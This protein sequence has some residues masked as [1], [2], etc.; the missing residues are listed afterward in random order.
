MR[1]MKVNKPSAPI[2]TKLIY[3]SRNASA[4]SKT[5]YFYY[6]DKGVNQRKEELIRKNITVNNDDLVKEIITSYNIKHM[7][8]ATVEEYYQFKNQ[9]TMTSDD[10]KTIDNMI[11]QEINSSDN[12]KIDY[13]EAT[14]IAIDK[15]ASTT[16]KDNLMAVTTYNNYISKRFGSTGLFSGIYESIDDL[17]Q[18]LSEH[19]NT[20][21]LPIISLKEKDAYMYNLDTEDDWKEKAREY[22][23]E[24]AKIV[25]IEKEN[26]R[27]LCA[28]HEKTDDKINI[29]KD[30]GKQPHLHF[31]IWSPKQNKRGIE[32]L[33]KQQL[34]KMRQKTSSIFL[35]DHLSEI[36]EKENELRSRLRNELDIYK[37]P[38]YQQELWEIQRMI[39]LG[40][41]GKGRL[42]H[43]SINNHINV[44]TIIMN[45]IIMKN[46]L[47]PQKIK[48]LE[49]LGLPQ[50]RYVIQERILLFSE[51]QDKMEKVIDTLLNQ[52][53][54]KREFN[55]WIEL[56]REITST[57]GNQKEVEFY[58]NNAIREFRKVIFN[59]LLKNDGKWY[60]SI[61]LDKKNAGKIID[62]AL[63][64]H[65]KHSTTKED[66]LIAYKHIASLMIDLGYTNLEIAKQ[67]TSLFKNI[68]FDYSTDEIIKV[69]STARKNRTDNYVITKHELKKTLNAINI[70]NEDIIYPYTLK[71]KISPF[72]SITRKLSTHIRT[73]LDKIYYNKEEIKKDY[74]NILNQ[75]RKTPTVGTI[76]R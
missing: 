66:M 51:A 17:K 48:Y 42:S 47:S 36:H 1:M 19:Q 63:N 18:E 38:Y 70:E 15:F 39:T 64:G 55:D 75:Y 29:L 16:G 76:D 67:T 27:W 12:K 71:S 54:L 73:D 41:G 4:S 25:G 20:V 13:D 33:S 11:K 24:F 53:P 37:S 49:K 32:R 40:T 26:L 28:Y 35:S 43:K 21:Y 69:I 59:T 3:I 9:V 65:F 68:K 23:D 44:L 22:V 56:K 57:W 5:S 45:D 14:K 34:S 62:K 46:P 6:I 58:T 10:F 74:E 52:H 7:Q 30:A 2:I 31:M 60:D 61:E 8:D 72:S 50:D